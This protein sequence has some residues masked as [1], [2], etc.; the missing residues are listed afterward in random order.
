[1]NHIYKVIWN[2]AK[3]C[4]TVVSEIAKSNHTSSTRRKRASMAAILTV[5]ALIGFSPMV[6]SATNVTTSETGVITSSTKDSK[7]KTIDDSDG[8][9]TYL[10]EENT[11]SSVVIYDKN[12]ASLKSTNA[13]SVGQNAISLG[14]KASTVNDSIAIGNGASVVWGTHGQGGVAIGINS[15]AGYKGISLGNNAG[16]NNTKESD[17]SSREGAIIIGD[18]ANSQGLYS[19]VVGTDSRLAIDNTPYTIL[20]NSALVQGAFSTSYG[21]MN[22]MTSNNKKVYSGIANSVVGS[23]NTVTNSNGVTIQGTGNT[24][25]GAYKDMRINFSDLLDIKKGDYSFLAK[26][27]S[28]AIAVIGGAN[29]IS[30]Q[31][32]STVI[33]F[34]NTLT[35]NSSTGT[36][37]VFTAGSHN[38]L[39]NVSNSL[40]MGDN[41]TLE[42]RTNVI[43]LGNGNTVKADN[44]VAIG[45]GSTVT[46]E[47]GV[48][49][50]TNSVA[51]RAV[52]DDAV[53]AFAPD[54]IPD[55]NKSIW[56][57][58]AGAVSVGD[59]NKNI[60]RQITNV[61]AGSEDTDAV[62]VAQ[63][64]NVA[65]VANKGWNLSTDKGT[66]TNV[67]PG[68]TVNFIGDSNITINNTD[69]NV[70]I[71]LNK[72]L[73]DLTSVTT[74]KAYV[75]NVDESDNSVTNVKYVKDQIAGATL[76]EGN[77]IS[78]VDK[79][80]NVKLKDGEQ[81][82]VVDKDGLSLKD[83]II[84]GDTGSDHSVAISGSKGTLIASNSIS[85]GNV[86]MDGQAGDITG[87]T[88]KTLDGTDFAKTGRAAT[89]EQLKLVS[90]KADT[91]NKGWNL[92]TNGSK[93]TTQVKPG[94][95]VDFSGDDNISVSNDGRNVKTTLNKDLKGIETITNGDAKINLN[96]TGIV[97][98]KGNDKIFS[99]T[100]TGM[101]MSVIGD[102]YITRSI[103]VGKNGTVIRGGLS[104]AG[105]K[106]TNVAAGEADTDA[107]N[108]GQL[109]DAI[110]K[111]NTDSHIKAGEY[112]VGADNKV[113][114]DIV[115]KNG[116]STGEKV[117]IKD[118]A[119]ASDIGD[120]SKIDKDIQNTDGKTTVVDAV[121][122]VNNKV[123][124]LN[125]SNVEKGEIA[126]GD[127]TTTAIGKLNQKLNNVEQTAGKHSSVSTEDSNLSISEGTNEA[128]GTDYKVSLNKDLTLDSVTTGDT[129][130]DTNGVKVGETVSLT[131]N[132]LTAGDTKVTNSG[133]S[134]G[135][136][137][138]VS[139]DGLNANNQ[140]VT[141]VS[142][143]DI[144]ADSK[145]A[146][147]GSQLFATNQQ[148]VQNAQ[149]INKLG[150]RI[151][152]VGAGAAALAAL[153]PL[154]FDPDD[155]WDFAAGYGNY[156]GENAMALG[157]YYRP[158]EDTMFSVGGS[159][160]NGENMVNA[161]ISL[162]LGQGNHVSTSKVAMAKE[163]KDLRKELEVLKSALLDM[164]AGKKM[165]TSKLQ[166]FPDVPKNH[167][168]YE[169]VATL[170]G[171]GML[172]GYPDGDFKGDRC[173]T[174]YE[175]ATMLYNA[176]LEGATLPEQML[177]E[178][179]PE[180]E[181]FTV[182]TVH[183]DKQGKPTV[184]RVR[185]VKADA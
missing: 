142:A 41:N 85:A 68:D 52:K 39:T 130:M 6:S 118:V 149:S 78:I 62:N 79:K 82:L 28:G 91:A 92:S 185:T 31:T 43:S 7:N 102:D 157:A 29:I 112:E 183:Q 45:N 177:Q 160:G 18:S 136:K 61:A 20:G 135:D 37:G 30:N 131:K 127:N 144:S 33:G 153:H 170:K 34:G 182:D 13:T 117:T 124:D 75:T 72:D 145:D 42:N 119:K 27:D 89:E 165:D 71:T 162:K 86:I 161:G 87:L 173:M 8:I 113:S 55:A 174:R 103:M 172:T 76:K 26:K 77:G 14:E 167:W 21:A 105:S 110:S 16:Q 184:E 11:D 175:F 59:A 90:D 125:Y 44:A 148:V 129:K 158:N 5:G 94:E 12:N 104:V 57:A 163:I 93:E 137:T 88:N 96:E 107:V 179:A 99:I 17:L 58:T 1:M 32:S 100:D 9:L 66:A 134:I 143:G 109:K 48:A 101:G 95:A 150:G 73:K 60:T 132:G 47:G 22:T 121:N 15:R 54:T 146:V 40:I 83:D 49:I 116:Q 123:G 84:L 166:L 141:N 35:G 128:G 133:L 126:D 64:R 176:M 3:H 180:L 46:A 155:K 65:S 138:Y 114:M 111:G 80:I 152:K 53:G 36:A 69:K 50:G 139:K 169:Y 70:S 25:T 2:Q 38:T 81:N 63:L 4:Y 181:R 106:I 151:N 120:V 122:N 74:N 10:A 164:H 115:D 168:A 23:V 147:N 19:T 159:F 56:T 178:F 156:N 67:A 154:D 171:N 140:K 24:V 97:I 108:V 51:D 98:S